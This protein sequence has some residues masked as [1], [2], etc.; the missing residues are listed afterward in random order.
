MLPGAPSMFCYF[1]AHIGVPQRL[2]ARSPVEYVCDLAASYG[3]VSQRSAVVNSPVQPHHEAD[4]LQNETT[5]IIV[6]AEEK[7]T[8]KS[9]VVGVGRALL[10]RGSTTAVAPCVC[11]LPNGLVATAVGFRECGWPGLRPLILSWQLALSRQPCFCSRLRR[12]LRFPRQPSWQ[13]R[14]SF[15]D[16][17]R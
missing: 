15:C 10:H 16:D 4:V 12:K 3:V 8:R 7:D 14:T 9:T 13:G 2:G 5:H 17:S 11:S 6:P 1:Y